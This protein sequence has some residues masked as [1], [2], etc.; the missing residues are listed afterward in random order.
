MEPLPSKEPIETPSPVSRYLDGPPAP[1]PA[2]GDPLL[3]HARA[4]VEL[5]FGPVAVRTFD[6]RYWDGSVEQSGAR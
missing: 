6:V 2:P 5:V 1:L 4:I 3:A